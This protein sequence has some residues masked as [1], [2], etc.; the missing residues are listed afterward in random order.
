VRSTNWAATTWPQGCFLFFE[1]VS[2]SGGA[3]M[4][5]RDANYHFEGVG[6][7]PSS[8]QTVT[9]EFLSFPSISHQNPFALIKFPNNSHQIPLVPINNP[10]KLVCS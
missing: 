5:P 3:N 1:G 9:I 4:P 10:S 2:Q 7:F 6:D 8:S